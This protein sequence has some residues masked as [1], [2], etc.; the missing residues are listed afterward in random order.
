MAIIA[1][2]RPIAIHMRE[3]LTGVLDG[4]SGRR[5]SGVQWGV[6]W[7]GV[8]VKSKPH[9]QGVDPHA[10]RNL[11]WDACVCPQTAGGL[12]NVRWVGGLQKGGGRKVAVEESFCM[13]D[14]ETRIA[15]VE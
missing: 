15:E 4:T 9:V 13:V 7:V 8:A 10:G 6:G 12:G 5:L 2:K 1:E 11:S 14:A 3:A